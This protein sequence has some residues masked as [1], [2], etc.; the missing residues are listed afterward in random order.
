MVEPGFT[1]GASVWLLSQFKE[2]V[3]CCEG[4]VLGCC[5]STVF[6]HLCYITTDGR[7]YLGAAV[8]SQA[9]VVDYISSKVS[10]WTGQLEV[11]ASFAVVQPHAAFAAFSCDLISKWLFVART[12]PNISHL[13][14]PL[15]MCVR[16]YFIPSVTGRSP[17]SDLERNLF[18]R[19]GGLGISN[20]VHLSSSEF[21]ASV[22]ITQPLQSLILLQAYSLVDDIRS[23][24]IKLK[25][26]IRHLKSSHIASVRSDLLDQQF[27]E[28]C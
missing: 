3:A 4:A 1:I 17:P 19:L 24:Q 9:Y 21:H 16:N 2:N 18:A 11:L 8:G 25:S 23:A 10:S 26:K 14:Q 28:I 6:R 20:P 13:F 7:P 5:L 22:K 12:V 15:E 27:K